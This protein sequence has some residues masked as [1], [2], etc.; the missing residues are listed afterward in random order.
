V[1]KEIGMT[2]ALVRTAFTTS[3]LLEFFSEKELTLQMGCT[4]DLWPLA[5]LK[6]LV[7]NALDACETAG[8][9]PEIA[10]RIEP[11][12][13]SIADNG[14]GLPVA[15]LVKSLD[16]TVRVSDKSHYVSPT[17]G[18]LGNALKCVWGA[19]FVVDG[20]QGT[21]EVYTG[22]EVHRI[23]V[24]LDRI[25][26]APRLLRTVERDGTVKTGTVV[27]LHWPEIASYQEEEEGP[28]FYRQAA[29]LLS[30]Y[31][32]FNPHAHFTLRTPEG[33]QTHEPTVTAWAKWRPS[34]PTSP[35]WYTP[36]R[37]STLIAGYLTAEQEGGRVVTVRDF[38]G[39]FA[40]LSGTAKRKAVVAAAGLVGKSL[41]DLIDDGEL[42]EEKVGCLLGQ[43]QHEAREILPATLGVLGETHLRRCLERDYQIEPVSL[44]YKKIVGVVRGVPFVLE[45]A[46]GWHEQQENARS[47]IG[48]N[49]SAALKDPLPTLPDLM[50]ENY[51][52]RADPVVVL[53]HLASPRLDF[54]ERGKGRLRLPGEIE[55]ALNKA[56]H[57]VARHW[58]TLKRH[59]AREQRMRQSDR[60][61]W[62]KK[63]QR[64][65]LN[66]KEAASVVMEDAYNA[67]GGAE[68]LPANARQIMYAAR[69]LVLELTGGKLW[70]NSSYFTQH[71]LPN[72]VEEHPELT[73]GWDV[74]FDDRGHFIE[75]HTQ[76]RIGIGTV[77]VR[78]YQ[79]AWGLAQE[80]EE[81]QVRLEPEYPTIGPD[82]RY[83]FALF[84]EK[85]GFNPLLEKAQL[86]ER[87]DLAIMSSKGMSTTAC[88]QLVEDLTAKGV[89]I[90]VL[91]DFDKSGFSIL[92]T[93]RSDTRRFH[94]SQTPRVIDLGLRLE[95][96]DALEL[97]SE[98]VEYK[99]R[100]ADPR[101]NLRSSGA[102][103]AEC[104]FLVRQ[105]VPGG[106]IGE[107]V[108][109]NAMTSRQLLTWLEAKLREHGVEK[110]VPNDATLAKAF[111][112]A[113]RRAA[114]QRLIDNAGAT[115]DDEEAEIPADLAARLQHA[116]AGTSKSWDRA[117]W[118]LV[119]DQED[120]EGDLE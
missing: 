76:T 42:A 5:L 59:L 2:S 68:G 101:E 48:L 26:Q 35:H 12:A 13:F 73:Q 19:P 49:W 34:D 97:Q 70:K 44:T 79:R 3:R 115:W 90:L 85:E 78:D 95:D 102:T 110:V 57:S 38:V 94:Y 61:H 69:P 1:S 41:H 8:V 86:A 62:K 36:E 18:Q 52:D 71:L 119:T 46:F 20:E 64:D 93:V 72:F 80:D 88:R 111:R 92:Q 4:P 10:V 87:Y 27:K 33:K 15:V 112:R 50:E 31:A 55:E 40:G 47:V 98:A 77:A 28:T 120:D 108:E 51:I 54:T 65:F 116:I 56:V 83:R 99:T 9:A 96:I 81:E 25:A 43:M 89:T 37:L 67:A 21:V 53:V 113:L 109:L 118:D 14:L 91:H 107:R 82:H 74:V 114:L 24:T 100:Y 75:P 105:Q 63:Q 60:E 7:D 104:E 58:K 29:D 16:Y 30:T 45:A 32:L 117:L 23:I 6:E 103:L 11:D 17:R 39:E 22:G 66:V 106:W 84:V